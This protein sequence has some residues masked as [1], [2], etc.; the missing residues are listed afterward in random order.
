MCDNHDGDSQGNSQQQ[1]K[2]TAATQQL[3]SP[4]VGMS[5]QF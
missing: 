1:Q 4:K 2:P 3:F 5:S